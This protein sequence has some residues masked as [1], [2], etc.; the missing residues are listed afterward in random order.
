MQGGGGVRGAQILPLAS[1][2]C[3]FVRLFVCLFCLCV[4][5][6]CL[7]ERSVMYD[8]PTPCLGN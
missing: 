5:L 6:A 1:V 7:S 3:L 2:S 8:T 4:L